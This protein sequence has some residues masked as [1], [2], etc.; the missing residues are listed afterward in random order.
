MVIKAAFFIELVKEGT[1]K[2]EQAMADIPLNNVFL[3]SSDL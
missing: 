1:P 3:F 2:I